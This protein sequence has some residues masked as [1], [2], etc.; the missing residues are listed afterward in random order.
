MNRTLR[1]AFFS[2]FFNIVF[3]TYH[4]IY[5]VITHSWWLITV[6]VYYAILSVVRFVVL[7]TKKQ[8]RFVT[9]FAGAMLMLLSLPLAGTVILSVVRDRGNK[10]HMIVMIAIAAYTFTKIILA[11]VN[12]IKAHRSAIS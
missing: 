3:A 9:R 12:F 8:K 1:L 7:K 11:T 2:L 6:G 10:L 4:V 5:G